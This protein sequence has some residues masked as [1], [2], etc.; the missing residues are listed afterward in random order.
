MA[1]VV[2]ACQNGQSVTLKFRHSNFK[3]YTL[4][5]HPTGIILKQWDNWSHCGLKEEKS[6]PKKIEKIIS[7]RFAHGYYLV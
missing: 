1:E 3:W 4:S 5:V 2:A 7:E 6:S